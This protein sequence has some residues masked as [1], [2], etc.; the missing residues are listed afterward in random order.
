MC[1]GELYTF[2]TNA[3]RAKLKA[4]VLLID[5]MTTDSGSIDELLTINEVA[6]L[7]KVSAPTV[8]RIQQQR[9]IPFFKVGGG[10]RFSMGDIIS[11]L[12]RQRVES[13]C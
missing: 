2:V 4:P 13:V 8:R 3:V 12:E 7:L 9:L 5:N 6:G 1:G 11:Y 10:I